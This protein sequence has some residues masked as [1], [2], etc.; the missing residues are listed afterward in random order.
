[1]TKKNSKAYRKSGNIENSSENTAISK[2]NNKDINKVIDIT[3]QTQI[4]KI[5]DKCQKK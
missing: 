3:K 1:M 2:K 5:T 4:L